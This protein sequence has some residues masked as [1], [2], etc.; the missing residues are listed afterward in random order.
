M[1]K[2][3]F[4][5]EGYVHPEVE[6]VTLY[7]VDDQEYTFEQLKRC[8]PHVTEKMLRDRLLSGERKMARLSKPPDRRFDNPKGRR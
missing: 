7:L 4:D 3:R 1:S 2:K 8:C 6:R 5:D